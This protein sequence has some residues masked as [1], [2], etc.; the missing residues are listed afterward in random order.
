MAL[1]RV[2]RGAAQLRSPAPASL[3]CIHMYLPMY[4]VL[5]IMYL[6]MYIYI[7]MYIYVHVYVCMYACM[8]TRARAPHT[9]PAVGLA[10]AGV[11][12]AGSPRAARAAPL[13]LPPPFM[14]RPCLCVCVGEDAALQQLVVA[15][16]DAGN[17]D[18]GA[19]GHL[20]RR[21]R[22]GARQAPAPAAPNDG[23]ALAS[24]RHGSP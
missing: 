7:H 17:D 10:E 6:P 13:A 19:E 9:H 22:S 4:Y 24:A 20:G 18:G 2:A 3:I 11:R 15:V 1:A 12:A 21:R 23:H 14:P 8:S 5:C 16:G